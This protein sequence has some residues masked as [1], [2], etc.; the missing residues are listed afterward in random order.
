MKIIVSYDG[1][2][3]D[4]D[5]LALGR[6]LERGGETLSLAYVR[7]TNGAD[8]GAEA[9]LAA[10]PD[11]QR[12]V[13]VSGSTAD[14]LREL[15]ERVLADVIVFGSDY[16]TTPGHVD[17]QGSARRLLEGGPTAVA[18]APSGMRTRDARIERV[19]FVAEDGDDAPSATASSLGAVVSQLGDADLVVVGSKP[20]RGILLS[21]AAQHLIELLRC[22]V[23][24]LPHGTPLGFTG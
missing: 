22:P 21:S 4:A 12:H 7:H 9:L 19:A 13:V 5:A 6:L 8:D 16:R 3:N 2:D 23:L 18:L 14:G 11:V 10:V 1:T 24:V 17:P 20:G 15:A